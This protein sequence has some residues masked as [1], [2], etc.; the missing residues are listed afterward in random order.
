LNAIEHIGLTLVAIEHTIGFVVAWSIVLIA[1]A[2]AIKNNL[3]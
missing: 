2:V 3:K 1:V